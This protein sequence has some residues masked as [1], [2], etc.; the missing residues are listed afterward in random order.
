MAGAHGTSRHCSHRPRLRPATG[1]ISTEAGGS[2]TFTVVLNTQPTADVTVDLSSSDWTEGTVSPASPTFT[3]LNWDTPQ[4]VTVTGVDDVDVDG[5]VAYTIVTGD[6]V[7]ADPDYAGMAVADVSVTNLDDDGMAVISVSSIIYAT[8]GGKNGDKHLQVTVS[9][10]PTVADASVSADLY[11][12]GSPDVSWTGTTGADGTVT[13]QRKNA[14][15]GT[16]TTDVI[17]VSAAGYEW[18][19]ATPPNSYYKP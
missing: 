16:Y 11:R 14:P 8:A 7:S 1:L 4:T 19:G 3:T 18:D 9:L 2:D 13:F 17:D 10:N 5:N 12:D 15:S 6:A